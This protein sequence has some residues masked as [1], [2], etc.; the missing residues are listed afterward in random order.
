M[1]KIFIVAMA[2]A[3][4]VS[5]SKDDGVDKVLTSKEKSV[6]VTI[7]NSVI[8]G[9]RATVKG[10]DESFTPEA[11][12]GEAGRTDQVGTKGEDGETETLVADL[13]TLQ[14]L[15]ANQAGQV[16]HAMPLVNTADDD[17]SSGDDELE[18]IDLD[19]LEDIDI[20]ELE[21]DE[22][23][24]QILEDESIEEKVELY[25]KLMKKMDGDYTNLLTP[26]IAKAKAIEEQAERDYALRMDQA[27]QAAQGIYAETADRI[28]GV[29][30]NAVNNNMDRIYN[31]LDEFLYA[32]T[33][34]GRVNAFINNCKATA[35]KVK[36]LPA[37][38]K[39][40]IVEKIANCKECARNAVAE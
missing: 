3:A 27:Q 32:K 34:P 2:L 33:L 12:G 36:Q 19:D 28:T 5:C 31:L 40:A 18:S 6:S 13:G 38:V 9:T 39:T 10:S 21:P 37:K 1:K 26:A 4:F 15:F 23:E 7:Q 35:A 25:D 24:L 8:S 20:D 30:D 14:I 16:L 29:V 11:I 22:A 17:M